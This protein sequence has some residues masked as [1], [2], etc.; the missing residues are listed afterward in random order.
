MSLYVDDRLVCRSEFR[1]AYQTVIYTQWYIPGVALVQLGIPTCIPDYR[2][3]IYTVTY[4]RH[5]TDTT[6]SP[7]DGHVAA[8]N[9]QRMEIKHKKKIVQFVYLQRPIQ[10]TLKMFSHKTYKKEPWMRSSKA[11]AT[12]G[13]WSLR[14]TSDRAAFCTMP[15]HNH[16]AYLFPD[17]FTTTYCTAQN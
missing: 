6:N 14:V 8:R 7:D 9:M 17:T 4:T 13:L 3:V 11:L 16:W 10:A 12:N 5:R 1:P 2:M 15:V